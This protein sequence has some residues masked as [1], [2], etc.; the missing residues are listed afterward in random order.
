MAKTSDAQLKA[1]K[2]YREK[3]R[4][5]VRERSYFRIARM[6]IRNCENEKDLKELNELINQ[7]IKELE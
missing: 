3:N 5:K 4:E 7:K 1:N 2:N 6:F